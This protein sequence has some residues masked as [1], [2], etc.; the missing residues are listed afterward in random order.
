[1]KERNLIKSIINVQAKYTKELTDFDPSNRRFFLE[2]LVG[3][4]ENIYTI[5]EYSNL[6]NTT[7][8][9]TVIPL[10]ARESKFVPEEPFTTALSV[11][12]STIGD[13]INYYQETGVRILIGYH[14]KS[15][16]YYNPT[17]WVS[18]LLFNVK[19]LV[20]Y[21][22]S[23]RSDKPIFLDITDVKGINKT[24]TDILILL[25]SVRT[26]VYRTSNYI[27]ADIFFEIHK[28]VLFMDIANTLSAMNI[29]R[30]RDII[31]DSMHD[32]LD[33]FFD[34]DIPVL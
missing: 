21:T 1:M 4:I 11:I 33:S 12:Y 15:Y 31:G 5:D 2:T 18:E 34:N 3:L 16:I 8:Y 20:K 10:G 26:S 6:V 29:S 23:W 24:I 19:Q 27:D 32:Y 22:K 28:R 14:S 7:Y 13:L 17:V 25:L 9:K 30:V